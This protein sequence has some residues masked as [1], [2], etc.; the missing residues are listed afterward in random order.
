MS[1]ITMLVIEAANNA[2]KHV[3]ARALGRHLSIS[4]QTTQ[5]QHA[6]LSVKDDGPGWS[7][8]ID[9]SRLGMTIID[10][11]VRQINGK[12]TMQVEAGTEISVVFPL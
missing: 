4:L 5:D 10:G 9:A 3:F 11:L 1:V 2:Q 7:G 6:C 8:T 12:L